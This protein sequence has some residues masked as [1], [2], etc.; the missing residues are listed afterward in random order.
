MRAELFVDH[1]LDATCR[2]MYFGRDELRP[3]RLVWG[4][5]YIRLAALPRQRTKDRYANAGRPEW[6][7]RPKVLVR[8][9]GDYVLAAADE[10]RRYASNNYFVVLPTL[11]CSLDV[12]GLAALLNSRFMTWYYRTA[13]PRRGR[14]FAEVKIR[15]L[16]AF[17]L[18]PEA[19]VPGGCSR[20]N[21]LGRRRA[22][23]EGDEA[24][25]LDDRIERLVD[26]YFG[27]SHWTG[28]GEPYEQR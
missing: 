17:P 27:V 1:P 14:A 26:G 28:T 2:E 19:E 15:H 11:P 12:Y 21:D 13:V 8:R 7:T 6:Y 9:T 3:H 10:S 16:L 25:R 24:Q 18:P 4:G 23:T 20:L 22:M 5:R